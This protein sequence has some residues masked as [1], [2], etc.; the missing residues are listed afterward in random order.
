M[1]KGYR[2]DLDR[3]AGKVRADLKAIHSTDQIEDGLEGPF[4]VV[5]C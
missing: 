3:K 1:G 4:T 5:V 2:A